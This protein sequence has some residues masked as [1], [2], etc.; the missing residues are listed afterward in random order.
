MADLI[1]HIPEIEAKGR[2]SYDL[3]LSPAWLSAAFADTD[4]RVVEGDADGGRFA[5]E[6]QKAGDDLVLQGAIDV[7]LSAPCARCNEPVRLAMHVPFTQ[8]LT[9]R[10]ADTALPEELELTPEDLE[11]EHYSGDT[12]ALDALVREAIL[13]EV[14]MRPLHPE[15]ECDP[16]IEATLAAAAASKPATGPLSGLA[17][18]KDKLKS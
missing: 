17:S 4:L 7:V 12:V 10:P 1:L 3:A 6:A 13:L 15:G 9:P 2:K 14:P 11:L 8:M 18:L 16:A 5:V